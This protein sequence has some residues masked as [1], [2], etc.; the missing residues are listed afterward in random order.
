MAPKKMPP[1]KSAVGAAATGASAG[2]AAT[3]ASGGAAAT[4]AAACRIKLI[5][6]VQIDVL[7][8]FVCTFVW[9][10]SGGLC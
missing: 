6:F 5:L 8:V 4:G 3:G 9:A 7:L 1:P 2:A 10:E